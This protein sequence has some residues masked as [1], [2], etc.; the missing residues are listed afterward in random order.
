MREQQDE[1]HHELRQHVGHHMA[2]CD[3]RR[4]LP[5]HA[6]NFDELRLAALQHLGTHDAREARPMRHGN[7]DGHAPEA[8]PD[9]KGDEHQK[10]DVGNAHHEVDQPADNG[11]DAFSAKRGSAPEDKRDHRRDRGR[12]QAHQHAR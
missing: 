7:A 1:P 11:I 10:H 12:Q 4:A 3:A 2:Q 5:Q 9:C 8:L 6:R